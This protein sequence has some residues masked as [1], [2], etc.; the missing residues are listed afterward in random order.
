MA[1]LT[2]ET[3]PGPG[4]GPAEPLIEAGAL[5]VAL[6]HGIAAASGA[7]VLIADADASGTRLGERVAAATR[8]LISPARRG[9]PTLVAARDGIRADLV[10]RH[11]W[12]LPSRHAGAGRVLL[13]AAATHRDGAALTARW[14]ADNAA[15]LVALPAAH[16]SIAAVLVPLGDCADGPHRC[17]AAAASVRVRARPHLGTLM[18]G[19]LRA[20][21]A[22][23]GRHADPDPVTELRAS[24]ADGLGPARAATTDGPAFRAPLGRRGADSGPM[25][26]V[27]AS[28]L[29]HSTC[30]SIL[31][32]HVG[33]VRRQA[34]LGARPNRREQATLDVLGDAAERLAAGAGLPPPAPAADTAEAG[35][36]R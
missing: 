24:S 27:T 30:A 19:G 35:G 28:S 5:A 11:C 8:T 6:A 32:G 25:S 36:A 21:A 29:A 34:L 3:G 1:A 26:P 31:L 23:F 12:V 15:A 9:L 17:L 4:T 20:L 16:H 2:S 13:C 10:E 33:G 14:L 7:D 18:P 22:A